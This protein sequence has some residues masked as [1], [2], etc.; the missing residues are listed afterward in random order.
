MAAK[1]ELIMNAR[2]DHVLTKEPVCVELT[3]VSGMLVA[4]LLQVPQGQDA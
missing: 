1:S 4:A 2:V 3:H